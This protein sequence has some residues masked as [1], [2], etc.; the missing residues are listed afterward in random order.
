[1]RTKL[2]SILHLISSRGIV[3][4]FSSGSVQEIKQFNWEIRAQAANCNFIGYKYKYKY[5]YTYKYKY[6]HNDFHLGVC[7]KLNRLT[8]NFEGGSKL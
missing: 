7:R 1:M 5:K 2:W 3:Q 6:K 4:Q 8:G